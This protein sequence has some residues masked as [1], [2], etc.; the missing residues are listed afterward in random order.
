MPVFEPA[1]FA[2]LLGLLGLVILTAASLSGIFDRVGLP[3]VALFL[4]LGT[5]LGQYGLG[6]I[7]FSPDSPILAT[8]ATLSLV[9]VLFTDAVSVDRAEVTRHL[10]LALV[11]LGPGTLLTTIVIT[12]AAKWLLGLSWPAAAI[13]GAA[14]AST[15]PVMVRGLLRQRGIPP[16]ARTALRIESGLND[17]IVLPIVLVGMSLFASGQGSHLAAEMGKVGGSVFILGPLA[18]ILVGWLSVRVLVLVRG[19]Y[20][21]RRDYESLYVLAVAFIAFASAELMHA[22]GFMAAFT[23][24]LTVGSLDVELCDC[25]RDYGEATAEMLLLFA[26]VAFGASLIWTGLEVL[27]P[28]GVGFAAVAVLGRT[29]VLGLT[30][31]RK[32]LDA[33]SRRLI[34]AFGPRALSSLLLVLLPVFAGIDGAMVLVPYAAL[35]VLMSVGLHGAMLWWF[36]QKY[37]GG[38]VGGQVDGRADGQDA[39]RISLAEVEALEADGAPIRMLD[40]RKERDWNSADSKLAGSIRLDPDHPVES[41]AERALPRSDWLI[42]YC[43]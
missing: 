40:V 2:A 42:G 9:L 35:A 34:V 25:F 7:E 4:G 18:G 41:A 24:G 12:G 38:P 37:G 36:A 27:S 15:D 33:A 32:S 31:P 21:M 16:A 39:L 1:T 29:A 11:V 10:K 22:S 20:G 17:V 8:I 14:L 28:A 26:F 30:L 23:A 19:K 5:I 13:L 6:L 43:A 3:L